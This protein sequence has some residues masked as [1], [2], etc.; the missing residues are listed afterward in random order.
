MIATENRLPLF[1]IM[2]PLFLVDD[3][4]EVLNLGDHAANR[5]GVLQLGDPADLVEL[6]ADQRRPLRGGAGGA[7]PG[8][9]ARPCSSLRLCPSSLPQ[10]AQKAP[11]VYPPPPSAPPPPRRDCRVD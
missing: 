10:K 3:A 9:S 2:L 7:A 8:G 6:E 4:D 11:V 1:G 5:R